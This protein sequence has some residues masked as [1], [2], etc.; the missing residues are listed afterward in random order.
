M[1]PNN[2]PRHQEPS[3]GHIVLNWS[4]AE[5]PPHRSSLRLSQLSRFGRLPYTSVSMPTRWGGQAFR[6]KRK[7]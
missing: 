1:A 5:R 4:L 2:L 6:T 7:F 3:Y